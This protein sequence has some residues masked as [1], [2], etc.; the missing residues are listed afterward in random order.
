MFFFNASAPVIH[1]LTR[2]MD[3]LSLDPLRVISAP[4]LFSDP[5]AHAGVPHGP[6]SYVLHVV[7]AGLR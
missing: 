6:N 7:V 3:E 5:H 1:Q 4:A 2:N